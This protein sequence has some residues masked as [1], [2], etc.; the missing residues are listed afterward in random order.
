[1][2]S[3]SIRTRRAVNKRLDSWTS[4]VYKVDSGSLID[5]SSWSF[6]VGI[7]QRLLS[8]RSQPSSPMAGP[9]NTTVFQPYQNGY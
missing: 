7:L 9:S 1:M 5:I 6:I 3:F 2:K 8:H 4:L